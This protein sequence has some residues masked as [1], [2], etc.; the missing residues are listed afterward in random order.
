MGTSAGFR[1]GIGFALGALV[2]A[3]LAWLA[4]NAVQAADDGIT[5]FP[6]VVSTFSGSGSA[7]SEVVHLGGAV[8]VDWTARPIGPAACQIR[9]VLHVASKPTELQ[10]L[11]DGETT[12]EATGTHATGRLIDNDYVI[13]V[14]SDC[15]WSFRLKTRS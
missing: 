10:V 8:D 1:F 13:D 7:T 5:L 14:A 6:P 9:A 11:V 3:A 12:T 4:F 15:A 2:I